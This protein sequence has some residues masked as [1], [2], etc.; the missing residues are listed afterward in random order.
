MGFQKP[1]MLCVL[2]I[3]DQKKFIKKIEMWGKWLV[4]IVLLYQYQSITQMVANI[5]MSPGICP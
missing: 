3:L 5:C 1:E 2:P 4:C